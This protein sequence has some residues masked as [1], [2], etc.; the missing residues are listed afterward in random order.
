[1]VVRLSA[2]ILRKMHGYSRLESVPYWNLLLWLRSMY[3]Y[4]A[5]LLYIYKCSMTNSMYATVLRKD[6]FSCTVQIF[7]RWWITWTPL[8]FRRLVIHVSALWDIYLVHRGLLEEDIHAF[9]TILA[10]LYIL[11][12]HK[13]S[14]SQSV[15]LTI[16]APLFRVSDVSSRLHGQFVENLDYGICRFLL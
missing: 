2:E 6:R 7:R 11:Q 5:V 9:L 16:R 10:S 14:R 15:G 1:M 4:R 12:H 13:P 8:S 3:S